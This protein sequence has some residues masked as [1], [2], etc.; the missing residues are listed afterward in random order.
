MERYEDAQRHLAH[1]A[2]LGLGTA[3]LFGALGYL[4]YRT[5][6]FLGAVNAFQEALML[7]P[8]NEQWKKGMLYSLVSTYRHQSALNLVEDMLK[9]HPDDAGLWL[10]RARASLESGNKEA[11][12]SSM[13]A[14]IRLG[15]Q[16]VSN[17][18]AC[19]A[20]HMELGGIA[21]AVDLL[22]SGFSRDMDFEYIDESMTWLE[23]R[24][25]WALLGQMLASIRDRWN[26]L[27]ELQRSRVLMRE[28]DISL[29]KGDKSAAGDAL[30]KAITL[31]PSNAYALMSLAGIYREKG[32]YNRAE[33]LYQ[34]ASAYGPYREKALVSLAQ[35]ALDQDNYSLAL[36]ILRKMLKEFPG[37]T[38]IN[39]NIESL[40]NL[41]LLQKG[42]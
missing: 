16:N 25:E 9:E 32:G 14:A 23:L 31:D 11:A 41:V 17:L 42:S 40:E 36:Q 34:R 29:H 28:A 33:L 19:A 38:D 35:L 13:E 26:S 30:E 1:A 2:D 6:N 24:E 4:N 8:D 18:Q 5:G 15:D 7:N 27:D 10:F 20:L 22:K 12:L 37:R 3:S 39:R 21:R